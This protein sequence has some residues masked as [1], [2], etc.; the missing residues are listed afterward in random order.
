MGYDHY[1][2]DALDGTIPEDLKNKSLR[3]EESKL[4]INQLVTELA[5]SLRSILP[6]LETLTDTGLKMKDGRTYCQYFWQENT[7]RDGQRGR[8][9]SQ[10]LYDKRAS[11]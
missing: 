4:D 11:D 10:S 2:D 8:G 5:A 1:L 9:K 3:R 6:T 7:S